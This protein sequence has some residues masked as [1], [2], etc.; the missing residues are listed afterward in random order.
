MKSK[1]EGSL[2]MLLQWSSFSTCRLADFAQLLLTASDLILAISIRK[3]K[4]NNRF[5]VVFQRVSS[6]I[7]LASNSHLRRRLF[8]SKPPQWSHKIRHSKSG[9]PVAVLAKPIP[10]PQLQGIQKGSSL[11]LALIGCWGIRIPQK[12]V[13]PER[14]FFSGGRVFGPKISKILLRTGLSTSNVSDDYLDLKN[15]AEIR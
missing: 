11:E 15:N 9:D 1:G 5:R 10:F 14:F 6:L 12:G 7:L 3:K 13:Q 4:K 8:N 2:K